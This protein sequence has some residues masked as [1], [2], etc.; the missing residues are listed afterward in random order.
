MCFII[1][2]TAVQIIIRIETQIASNMDN[3][4]AVMNQEMQTSEMC[5][6]Y[7]TIHRYVSVLLRPSSSCH[8]ISHNVQTVTQSSIK[9]PATTAIS[10]HCL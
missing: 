4:Y 2:K 1:L 3:I 6:S 5:L 8:T 7:I 10:K 9:P